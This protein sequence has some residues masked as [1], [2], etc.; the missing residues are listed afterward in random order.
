MVEETA[1]IISHEREAGL[2]FRLVLR[3]SQIAPQV[4]PGQF[5][6]VRILPLK[7]AL[8]RRPFSVFQASELI[9]GKKKREAL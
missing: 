3:A 6:H 9:L 1:Q 2:Y 7:A 4:Q 8:L 5:V